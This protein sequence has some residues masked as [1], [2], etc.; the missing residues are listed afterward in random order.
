MDNYDNNSIAPDKIL[1]FNKSKKLANA[2]NKNRYSYLT[3]CERRDNKDLIT[4]RVEVELPQRPPI[5][6]NHV[7]D[8]QIEVTNEKD[9]PNVFAIRED[10]P[11]TIHQNIIFPGDPKWLCLYEDPWEEISSTITPELFIER[12]REWLK[13]AA[14]NELHLQDQPL[15]PYLVTKEKIIISEDILINGISRED[16]L[17]GMQVGKLIQMVPILRTEVEKYRKNFPQEEGKSDFLGLVVKGEPT[18]TRMI[19]QFP[20]NLYLLS[21]LLEKVGLHICEILE[22]YILDLNKQFKKI[23]QFENYRLLIFL[24]LPKCRNEGDEPKKNEYWVFA[25]DST[26]LELGKA[27]DILDSVKG[28][29]SGIL[30]EEKKTQKK[31]SD[32][33]KKIDVYAIAPIFAQSKS[34]A[35]KSSGITN[36]EII[37]KKFGIIGLG[38]L[39]SQIVMNLAKQGL[40]ELILIDNDLLLPHNLARHP[41][42]NRFVG[43]SKVDAIY[44]SFVESVFYSEDNITTYEMNYLG[45]SENGD[46]LQ[47]KCYSSLASTDV[48]FDFSASRAVSQKLALDEFSAPRLSAYL[49]PS[50]NYCVVLYEGEN[51]SVR[52]DDLE[53]QLMVSISEKYEL[54]NFWKTSQELIQ[55]AGSCRDLSRVMSN[56]F[57]LGYSG[58]ISRLIKN[59][60]VDKKPRISV[61]T[62][63]ENP[64]CISEIS[65]PVNKVHVYK[66]KEWEIRT[67]EL[68]FSSLSEIR[69]ERLPNETGGILL[70][71]MN[72]ERK[73]IHISH[74]LPSPPDS[75]EW[76]MAYIRGV[77]GLEKQI[78]KISDVTKN[79]LNYIGEWHS[80]PDNT[81]IF[82]SKEDL[83][84]LG[85]AS[86]Y[87]SAIGYPGLM[88]ILGKDKIKYLLKEE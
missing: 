88:A 61:F 5:P 85:W 73:I 81:S 31:D 9:I 27:L 14:V 42:I 24:A 62:W 87:M 47:K 8:I 7:E 49:T 71:K 23:S 78:D 17:V 54:N 21:D 66:Q 50:G 86:E 10:F 33:L 79:G 13:R 12:I 57:F 3:N 67:S 38:A 75:K 6:I 56:D 43:L 45:V 55:I 25:I 15:E 70:G 69:K 19:S 30:L 46:D 63:Q 1:I 72:H 2:I 53:Q 68:T 58:V 37:N 52:L 51:R 60:L 4:L 22:E 64:Q 18:Y 36:E 28:L 32:S 84:A 76:P 65:I 83:I 74:F 40:G 34:L 29:G 41:L 11:E 26:I 59:I 39:G 20:N 16:I 80:H 82:P 35:R 77:Q 48:I 44:K